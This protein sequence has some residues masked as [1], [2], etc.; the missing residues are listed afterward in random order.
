MTDRTTCTK[1][2]KYTCITCT[3]SF[4]TREDLKI[5]ENLP[6]LLACPRCGGANAA[7]RI[8][9]WDE[10]TIIDTYHRQQ[11]ALREAER[12]LQT[13]IAA[14]TNEPATQKS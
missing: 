1:T 11:E 2:A 4:E 9:C 7:L 5:G 14:R 10:S 6:P 13:L 12:T 3:K 8:D